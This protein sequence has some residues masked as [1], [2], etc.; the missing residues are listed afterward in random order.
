MDSKTVEVKVGREAEIS[1]STFG[2][3]KTNESHIKILLN[4]DLTA[5]CSAVG[6]RPEVRS[7]NWNLS[8]PTTWTRRQGITQFS[9][10]DQWGF[11]N[12]AQALMLSSNY[13]GTSVLFC[14]PVQAGYS[15]LSAM[16]TIEVVESYSGSD[17]STAS[18]HPY[19]VALIVLA[20]IALFIVLALIVFAFLTKTFCFASGEPR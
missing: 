17:T 15:P 13:T 14:S 7:F 4:Q 1:L 2:G 3:V 18:I 16:L 6:G 8:Y 12:S 9:S 19:T 5:Q 11:R 10:F 20:S